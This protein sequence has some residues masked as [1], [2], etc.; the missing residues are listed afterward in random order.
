MRNPKMYH[1]YQS[2]LFHTRL[3]RRTR[4]LE[5][6]I[7]ERTR[8]ALDYCR[9]RL[10]NVPASDADVILLAVDTLVREMV[11]GAV[12]HGNWCDLDAPDLARF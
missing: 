2:R 5:V 1:H 10:G 4:R 3:Q 8:L 7:S 11:S 6:R 12:E 9:A